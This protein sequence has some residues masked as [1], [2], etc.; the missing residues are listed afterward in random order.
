MCLAA[1]NSQLS[2]GQPKTTAQKKRLKFHETHVNKNS[3]EGDLGS[4]DCTLGSLSAEITLFIA[5]KQ[6]HYEH[7]QLLGNYHVTGAVWCY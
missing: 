6:G 5:I 1:I 2:R 3:S 7:L 4:S